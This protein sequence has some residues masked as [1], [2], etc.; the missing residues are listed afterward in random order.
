MAYIN[1]GAAYAKKGQHDLA[2]SEFTK[3]IAINPRHADAYYNRAVAYSCTG[4]YE[5]TWDDVHK[6]QSLG[7]QVHPGFLKALCDASGRER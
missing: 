7:A 2:I 5:E 6:A 3:A 4:K 1:R